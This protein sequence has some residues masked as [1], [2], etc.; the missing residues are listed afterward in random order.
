MKWHL[1][2]A[3]ESDRTFLYALHS[4]TMRE[5]IEKTWGWDGS[6]QQVDFERRFGLCAVS[7]IEIAGEAVGGLWLDS[8]PDSLHIVELQLRPDIQGQGIGTAVIR[9]VIQ[10]AACF[11]LPVTLSVVPANPRAQKLYERLGFE[12]TGAEGPLVHMRYG[13]QPAG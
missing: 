13:R 4:T 5:V 3:V 9:H 11:E 7:I 12:V 6:W 1:R 2:D 8:K 10:R